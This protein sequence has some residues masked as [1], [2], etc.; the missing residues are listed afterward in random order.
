MGWFVVLEYEV[1][2]WFGVVLSGWD[3]IGWDGDFV[4][5]VL[6][7]FIGVG[8]EEWWCGLVAG[9]FY[10]AGMRAGLGEEG[11]EVGGMKRVDSTV[12]AL[13]DYRILKFRRCSQRRSE[14]VNVGYQLARPPP[15][16]LLCM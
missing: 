4:G 6:W 15:C 10:Q 12:G 2:Y 13:R 1:C 5:G 14:P 8:C 16:F 7:C 9:V 3:V 11:E